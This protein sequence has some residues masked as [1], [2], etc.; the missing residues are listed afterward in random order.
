[1]SQKRQITCD[2]C[3]AVIIDLDRCGANMIKEYSA[4]IHYW[5]VGAPRSFGEQR[6][7]L[8]TEC[9]EKFV[10]FLGNEEGIEND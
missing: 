7:D 1:M 3:G 8:C 4:K 6:I 5:G 2:R 9:A 10:R